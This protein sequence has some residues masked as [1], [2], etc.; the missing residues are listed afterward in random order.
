MTRVHLSAPAH[1]PGWLATPARSSPHDEW[2]ASTALQAAASAAEC[3]ATRQPWCSGCTQPSC[4]FCAWTNGGHIKSSWGWTWFASL[5]MYLFPLSKP[6]SDWQ[7]HSASWPWMR[8]MKTLLQKCTLPG[9]CYQQCSLYAFT[10]TQQTLNSG[11]ATTDKHIFDTC[12]DSF[13]ICLTHGFPQISRIKPIG[14]KRKNS[15]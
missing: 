9:A 8:L 3:T 1:Q 2:G 10:Y 4:N 12:F 6:E 11:T 15:V 5:K 13:H 14:K 7:L